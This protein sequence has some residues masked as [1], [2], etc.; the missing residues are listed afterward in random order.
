MVAGV[1]GGGG[2]GGDGGIYHYCNNVPGYDMDYLKSRKEANRVFSLHLIYFFKFKIRLQIK[3][4]L[5]KV[6]NQ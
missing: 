2:V 1:G 4:L 5:F 6:L 3:L